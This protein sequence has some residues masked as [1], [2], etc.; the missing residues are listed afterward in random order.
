MIDFI[1][2]A[3]IIENSWC[4]RHEIIV[5]T[6]SNRTRTIL[7]LILNGGTI[8]W[9]R[10]MIAIYFELHTTPIIITHFRNLSITWDI[11]IIW[12]FV[13]SIAAE[14]IVQG[15]IH[16]PTLT[17][18]ITCFICAVN[19]LLLWKLDVF[20][21]LNSSW[22]LDRS[23]T[24][25]CPTWTTETLILNPWYSVLISP[26]YSCCSHFRKVM[27]C[28]SNFTSSHF[29]RIFRWRFW[30][31]L[32]RNNFFD[33]F[34]DFLTCSHQIRIFKFFKSQSRESVVLF[35]VKALWISVVSLDLS[36]FSVVEKNPVPVLMF[37]IG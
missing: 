16:S 31:L 11:R 2:T 10:G 24:C 19:K 6:K 13:D 37:V 23:H 9:G 3:A 1:A 33:W 12:T 8:S 29:F 32:W 5:N 28:R 14:K 35:F 30:V 15:I 36:I 25:K 27:F 18:I 17:R 20:V 22:R 7:K 34:Q 21:E 26:V 4:I